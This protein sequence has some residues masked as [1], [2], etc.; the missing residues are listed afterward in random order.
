[1]S[2]ELILWKSLRDKQRKFG[3]AVK[4]IFVFSQWKT[5][6]SL[7][8]QRIV[9]EMENEEGLVKRK[10]VLLLQHKGL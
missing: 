10:T 9:H 6:L 8:I 2:L 4:F 3:R 7:V 5:S 1:M